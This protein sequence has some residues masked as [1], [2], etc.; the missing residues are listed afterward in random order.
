[1]MKLIRFFIYLTACSLF[2]LISKAQEIKTANFIPENSLFNKLKE[3]DSLL[4]YQCHVET[5][6]QEITTRSGQQLSVKNH[7]ITIT[8]KYVIYK[9]QSGYRL[10]YFESSYTTFPN[11]KFAGLKFKE[12]PIWEFKKKKESTM[13][14]TAIKVFVALEKKGNEAIVY[15]Y[16]IT[17]YNKNQIIIRTTNDY[18]QLLIEGDYVISKLIQLN[19]KN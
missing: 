3:N 6:N 12:K 2:I 4:I 10:S 15:D 19:Q 14:D 8:E 16:Y 11:K 7:E 5:A 1:M 9:T 13:G 18:R 17:R